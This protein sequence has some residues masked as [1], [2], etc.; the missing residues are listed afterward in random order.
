MYNTQTLLALEQKKWLANQSDAVSVQLGKECRI[1]AACN[2][3]ISLAEDMMMI[4]HII[5]LNN[6]PSILCLSQKPQSAIAGRKSTTT[7]QLARAA[8]S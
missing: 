1:A 6:I 5:V 2:H 4:S 8:K 3:V 7:V